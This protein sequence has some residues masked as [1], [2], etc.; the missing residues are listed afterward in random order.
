MVQCVDEKDFQPHPVRMAKMLMDPANNFVISAAKLKTHDLVGVTLSL[1][2]M[3][4]GAGIKDSGAS[5]GN[6]AGRRQ[7]GQAPDPWRRDAWDQLQHFH[8]VAG[9]APGPGGDR[10]LRGHGRHGAGER[11][12]DQSEGLHCEYGLAG[13]RPGRRG[14]D[15]RG[16]RKIGYLSFLREGRRPR[17]G[18][19]EQNPDRGAAGGN[20]REDVSTAQTWDQITIGRSRC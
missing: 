9:A 10:R 7:V 16:L 1:K 18:R 13:C 11:N 8:A 3:V 6:Q 14:A 20:S 12:A 4:V 19:P 17:P 15:G 5:L 2:N